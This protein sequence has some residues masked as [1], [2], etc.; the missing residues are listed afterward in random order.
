M[1]RLSLSLLGPLQITLD[2]QPVSGFVYNK[3][4]ALLAYL[5]I[6]AERPHQRDALVGLLWPEL[7]D[8]AARTNL[9]QSLANLRDVIGDASAAPPFLLITRDSIQFNPASDY[10]LDAAS[11]TALL[12]ACKNHAHRRPERCQSCA[13]RLEQASALYRGDFLAEFTLLDSAPFEEWQLR[14]RERLHQRALDALANLANYHERRGDDEPAH[15]YAQRQ[16]EFDPWREEAH[17]Q[18]MRLLA[19]GGQRSAA[20]AQYAT[21]RRILARDLGVEP[22]AETTALYERIRDGASSELRVLSSELPVQ[23]HEPQTSSLKPQ[24]VQNFPAQTSLLIGRETELADIGA[25]LE[26]PACR[27]ITIA[28]P[29][30]IG[31]TR[32]ALAAAAEQAEVFAGGAAFVPLQAISSATFLAPTILSALDIPLQGQ[33]NPRE[34]LLDYVRG[35]EMLLVLDNVEQLLARDQSENDSIAD[36][37]SD[38]LARAPGVTLLVTSRERLALPGEWLFDLSGLDYPSGEPVNG[39]EGY[40][41]VRLFMQRAG[42][43]RRQFTL[44]DGEARAVARI[45]LLVEGLPLAIELAAAALR[46]RSCAAIVDSIE[47]SLSVLATGLRAVPERHRSVWATFEHSWRL[48]SDEERQVLRRLAVFRGGFEQDA[49]GQVAQAR[50]ELLEALVDKSLLR[51]DGVARYDIHELVRQYAGEKLAAA[52]EVETIRQKHAEYYLALAEAAE[53]RGSEH[54]AW[55]RRLAAEQDNLRAALAHFDLR[56]DHEGLARICVALNQFWFARGHVVEGSRWTDRALTL[57]QKLL[58]ERPLLRSGMLNAAGLLLNSQSTFAQARKLLTESLA[59][60]TAHGYD[61]S[62]TD[63]LEQLGMTAF[64]EDDHASAMK[65]WTD[66]LAIARKLNDQYRSAWIMSFLCYSHYL[67]GDVSSARAM[68]EE[69]VAIFRTLGVRR[70]MGNVLSDLGYFVK[71]EGDNAFAVA[72][73]A[74]SITIARE[75]GDRSTLAAALLYMGQAEKSLGNPAK[76]IT[77]LSESL[78]IH[79]EFGDRR[80]CIGVLSSLVET[81]LELDG[82]GHARELLAELFGL[83]GQIESFQGYSW[84]LR[85]AA[86]L[87]FQAGQLE[88]ATLLLGA[89]EVLRFAQAIPLWPDEHG[90]YEHTTVAA[91]AALGEEAFAATWAEGRTMTLEQAIACALE[92]SEGDPVASIRVARSTQ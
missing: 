21:C 16:I 62:R 30:G 86:N 51:W 52:G 8:T 87:L 76:A 70:V 2:G 54:D 80:R 42:Q 73:L 24:N 90:G 67:Q 84:G 11:F 22:E 14:Q 69:S 79:R 36:L 45:C 81:T 83:C 89:D 25:L 33:R 18:L 40:N 66:G 41:A 85:G 27:L 77:L 63:A 3:A 53:L 1:V 75:A 13:A 43:V 46:A 29:G 28:G 60:A 34:Q 72:L 50:P 4:R 38:L 31:K 15:H 20:L 19:R 88:Q 23:G 9:R 39:I 26:N 44:A 12:A 7:P 35:K 71:S 49:A 65:H 61:A 92:E 59:L 57:G 5:A 64:W 91:R 68:A 78:T 56:G 74:E 82:L 55:L 48:L 32:L 6:E 10:D 17:C 47:S 58:A 37:L